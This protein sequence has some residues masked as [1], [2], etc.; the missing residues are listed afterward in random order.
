MSTVLSLAR[1]WRPQTFDDLVGQEFVVRAVTNALKARKLPQ[2][3]L[4]SGERGVGKTTVARIL[5]KA[6]NCERGPTAHPCQNCESCREITQGSSPDVL[7]IDGA[8]H[9]SVDDIRTLREGIRYLPLKSRTRVYIIDE[10]HMLSQA[11]FNALLKTLE[12]PPPHVVFVFATTED[13]KIPET[14]LSRC[15]HFRFRSLNVSEIT[16]E[17]ERISRA[18]AIPFQRATLNLLARAAGGSMRDGLSLLDQVRFL[19]DGLESEE[20]VALFLGMAGG[21]PEKRLLEAFL[22]GDVSGVVCESDAILSRGVDPRMSLRALGM[23]VRDLLLS[24]TLGFPLS[25]ARFG[26]APEEIPDIPPGSEP[27][28]FLLEQALSVL[29]RGEDE[30][31]R[32]SQSGVTFLLILCRI[33][34]IRNVLPIPEILKRL[35]SP[36]P[37][38]SADT[39]RNVHSS[40]VS[41]T[42]SKTGTRKVTES[43]PIPRDARLPKDWHT[44]ISEWTDMP[45]TLRDLLGQCSVSRPEENHY[46]LRAPNGFFEKRVMEFQAE[47]VGALSRS[48]GHSVRVSVTSG[49]GDASEEPPSLDAIVKNNPLVREALSLFGGDIIATRKGSF[50]E[51]SPPS[52]EKKSP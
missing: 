23:K 12:E 10:V 15:Q 30:I 43:I 18:E 45:E 13:H 5:A 41:G 32:S 19:S 29:L 20:D 49:T 21:L 27:T 25:D 26:W 14:I 2:A 24:R 51:P 9:T 16:Q 34:H 33:A 36:T 3:F 28:P 11:A 4:F 39:G 48:I 38:T 8:S 31:R 46:L 44:V 40:D 1:K 37:Q 17:L 22:T 6:I 52:Q 47:I 42:G 7:E 50:E 35:G